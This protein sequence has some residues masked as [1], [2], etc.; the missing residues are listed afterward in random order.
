MKP[1]KCSVWLGRF[2]SVQKM[3]H[4]D[5]LRQATAYIH[6]MRTHC[7]IKGHYSIKREGAQ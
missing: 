1:I 7:N 2:T 6:H 4:F 3:A 5:S